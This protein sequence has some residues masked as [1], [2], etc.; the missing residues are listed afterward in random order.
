MSEGGDQEGDTSSLPDV[1][2]DAEACKQL[3]QEDLLSRVRSV[4]T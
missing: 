3:N 2:G 1:L 4:F